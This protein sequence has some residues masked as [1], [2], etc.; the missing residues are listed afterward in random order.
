VHLIGCSV[1]TCGDRE[2]PVGLAKNSGAAMISLRDA[3]QSF[4][5]PAMHTE[6]D[7]R[8]TNPVQWSPGSLVEVVDVH[9]SR[10]RSLFVGELAVIAFT[11][12]TRI[13]DGVDVGP[14]ARSMG[15]TLGQIEWLQSRL[16]TSRWVTS[17]CECQESDEYN[18]M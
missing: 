2:T 11:T 1:S 17:R 15:P 12:R 9:G 18:G 13:G 7:H 10:Q 14:V 16:S 3:G 8:F 4:G 6:K 5:H